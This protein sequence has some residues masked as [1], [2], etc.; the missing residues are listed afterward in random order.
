M[1]MKNM[2]LKITNLRQ[3]AHYKCDKCQK[4]TREYSKRV[5]KTQ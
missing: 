2:E 1:K 4:A 5:E 3:Y